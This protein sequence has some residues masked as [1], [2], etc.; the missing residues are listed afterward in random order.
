MSLENEADSAR[1]LTHEAE[2]AMRSELS[3]LREQ[4]AQVSNELLEEDELNVRIKAEVRDA[5]I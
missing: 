1:A 4:I 2:R 5:A 3:G